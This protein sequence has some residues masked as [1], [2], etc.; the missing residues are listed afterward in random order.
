MKQFLAVLLGVSIAAC[1]AGEPLPRGSDDPA[2]AAHPANAR[3]GSELPN[4][5]A[6]LGEPH[7]A[8]PDQSDPF[9]ST[10]KDHDAAVPAPVHAT[11]ESS[12]AA[13]KNTPV[14]VCPMHPEI[15]AP[16]PGNCPKCGM[17]LVVRE[18][19]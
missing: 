13:G 2:L 5:G 14:Y 16:A 8:M 19:P 10:I 1:V 15:T 12:P 4:V 7:H 9:H 18:K 3:V 17:P 11:H 6:V